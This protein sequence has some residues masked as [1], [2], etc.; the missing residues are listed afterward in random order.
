L[1]AEHENI[2]L[3]Q[4]QAIFRLEL[5]S[6][7]FSHEFQ[8]IVSDLVVVSGHEQLRLLANEAAGNNYDSLADEFLVLCKNK[9]MYDQVRFLDATGM[10]LI[11][12]NFNN[13][14]PAIVPKDQLQSKAGRYYFKGAISL[15][16]GEVFVSPLDLNIEGGAI[17]QPI[18]PTIR[19]GLPV[20]NSKGEKQGIVVLNYFATR[21]MDM[22][23]NVAHES[24][25]QGF[26]LLINSDGYF[27][28]GM[29]SEDE[30]GFML[31][32]RKDRTFSRL[33]P[34]AWDRVSHKLSGQILDD[35]GLFTFTT[36]FPLI[37][38]LRSSSG[39]LEEM[40]LNSDRLNASQYYWKIVSFT[41]HVAL[42]GMTRH[43][44]ILLLFSN[45]IFSLLAGIG[46]W[47]MAKAMV[48]RQLAEDELTRMAHFDLLTGLPNRPLLYDR[49]GVALA[50]AQRNKQPL[51]VFFLDLDG[52]K[53]VN[54]SLGHE[55]G[56]HVLIEVATR[57]QHC[58]RG[59]DTVA[60]L[61]G[62]EFVLVLSSTTDPEAAGAIATKVIKT[63]SEPIMFNDQPCSIGAS[64]GIAI[65]PKDG[66]TQDA[67]MSKADTA[68]YAAKEGGKNTYR[69]SS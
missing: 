67:L 14:H 41:P 39:S 60:R 31:P 57:L 58:I 4:E 65:Y 51:S 33:F 64:I 34:G 5:K 63:L 61:G 21:L 30:W 46:L 2:E 26:G 62:D 28:K 43:L 22:I 25:A 3:L 29:R 6:K 1:S 66:E 47:F 19:F 37:E 53:G 50:N 52:F 38:G 59:S 44:R 55:A 69:F 32:E 45:A 54:D 42:R 17:E 68:M 9:K 20:F 11:R 49:L 12:A 18:K 13:G 36:V 35:Q 23:G 40:G 8:S 56:D 24:T 10:E 27:L 16:Q 15:E 48:K 7:A